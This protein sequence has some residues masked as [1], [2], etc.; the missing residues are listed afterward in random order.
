MALWRNLILG[1]VIFILTIFVGVYGINTFYGKPPQYNDYCPIVTP[2]T[3]AECVK[4]NGTWTNYNEGEIPREKI[5]TP[6]TAPIGYCDTYTYCQKQL[7][8]AEKPYYKGIFIIAIPLGIIIIALGL[9]IF[10]LEAVGLGLMAGGVGLI[11]YGAGSYWRFADDVV[12]FVLS[13][14]GL[15]IVILLAYYFNQR[16]KW[17]FFGKK[18]EKVEKIEKKR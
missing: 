13:F 6:A 8:N 18:A 16:L 15:V 14:I 9:L 11:V 10:H 4:S 7:E 3:Q 5:P 2:Q 1:I 12:K 17:N